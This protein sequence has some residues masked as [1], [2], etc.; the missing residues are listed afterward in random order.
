MIKL[1]RINIVS[2]FAGFCFHERTIWTKVDFIAEN[3]C[4]IW[5]LLMD[6]LYMIER[7]DMPGE[8][9]VVGDGEATQPHLD[10][11]VDGI[12][13]LIQTINETGI[14]VLGMAM[15]LCEGQGHDITPFQ[16]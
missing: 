1:R 8:A 5:M 10:C 6:T 7:L 12:R 11:V 16:Q 2:R 9:F 4:E 13:E 15:K 3:Q 14:A